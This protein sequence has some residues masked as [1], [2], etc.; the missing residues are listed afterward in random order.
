MDKIDIPDFMEI[1]GGRPL[2]DGASVEISGAKNEVLGAMCAAILTDQ[3][4]KFNNIPFITDV[5][6]LCG[7]MRGIGIKI[8][9]RPEEKR[10]T[11][12]AEKITG[13]ALPPEAI[14]FRASYYIWGALLARFAKTGEWRSLKI[15]IPG[16]CSFSG[17]RAIDYHEDL[18]RNMFGAGMI[19][20]G[21]YLEFVLPESFD[22]AAR[23]IYS[24][25]QVSH[26]ATFH[27][28]L[29]AALSPTPKMIYN[30]SLE[31]EVPHLLG[32]LAKM[33]ANIRGTG[34]TA[35][36]GFG[37]GGR[38]LRGGTFDILPDRMETGFYALLAMGLKSKITLAGT[39][40]D[41][42]RPWLNSVIEIAGLRRC[43][44]DADSMRFDFRDLPQFDGRRFI[45]SPIPGKETDMQQI[46]APILGAARTPSTIYDPVWAGRTGH[47]P[48]M[49]KFGL[50]SESRLVDINNSVAPRAAEIT[51]HPSKMKPAA[52]DGMDLR[53]TAGLVVCAAMADGTSRIK[54]PKYALRGYPN[55]IE[56]L[57]RIGIDVRSN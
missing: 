24:T 53:G 34:T 54:D 23:P 17:A 6:D 14:K 36:T 51:I 30:A 2:A 48:E 5:L 31:P 46:W 25:M 57:K 4:V 3:P 43:S 32:I 44:I 35:I 49:A 11:I 13:N 28:L 16:G 41:S 45:M 26:G 18:L 12:H 50:K 29:S 40:A 39:D 1:N 52:A 21:E 55:L 10:M 22:A 56:N 37:F 47:L 9:Y 27:W 7:I 15:R 19:E 8:D 33:G 42:C 38:L 20:S